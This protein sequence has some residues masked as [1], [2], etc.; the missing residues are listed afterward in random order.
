MDQLYLY[1]S[2]WGLH[3]GASGLGLFTFDPKTGHLEF[4]K[5]LDDRHSFGCSVIDYEKKLL[6][7]SNETNLKEEVGYD[8]GRIYG[9]HLDPSTGDLEDFFR[10]ETYCPFPDYISFDPGHKYMIVPHHSWATGITTIERDAT[11]RYVPM[12][13][14]MDSAI[15]LFSL[16]PDGSIRD[17]V[18]VRK[19]SFDKPQTDFEGKVTVPHP[20][21]AV[22]S[23]SGKLYAVCDKGDCRLYLY[24]LDEQEEKLVLLNRFMTDVPLAEPRYCAFHPTLPYLFVNHEHAAHGEITVSALRYE[25]DGHL[26]LV[27]KVNCLHEGWKG[28]ALGQG[29]CI[30]ADGKY[31]YNQIQGA[32]LMAVLEIDQQTGAVKV[33]Q[34]VDA[35]NGRLRHCALS[36][37][38]RFL[39]VACLTGEILV[40]AIGSDGKLTPTEEGAFFKGSAYLTFCDPGKF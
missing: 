15:D 18:D 2:Q 20:H 29:F 27:N 24:T 25:E 36:P 17:L 5:Q 6:Y 4:V 32:N 16:N 34:R 8:T 11:G 35:G 21:C 39:V 31:L 10:R 14:Y 37:D 40:Y 9:Y 30:S 22:R 38:G 13:R 12:L 7:I 23:P 19:H 1:V 3:G 26:E 33:I 28:H